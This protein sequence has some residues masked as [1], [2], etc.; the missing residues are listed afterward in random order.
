MG[1]G[2]TPPPQFYKIIYLTITGTPCTLEANSNVKIYF[3]LVKTFFDA[4]GITNESKKKVIL[5]SS[6]SMSSKPSTQSFN[7]LS[8]LL[9]DHFSY[10]KLYF[11][12]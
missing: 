2:N 11:A 9:T 12:N 5:L 6:T 3:C 1:P 7:T 10:K 8:K 4:S